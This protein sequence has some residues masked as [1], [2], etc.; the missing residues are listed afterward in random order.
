MANSNSE[1]KFVYAKNWRTS[2]D[3]PDLCVFRSYPSFLSSLIIIIITTI[4]TR[5]EK[6]K[7]GN[8][9]IK[10]ITYPLKPTELNQTIHG[11]TCQPKVQNEKGG[12]ISRVI[13]DSGYNHMNV[14]PII[15]GSNWPKRII[16]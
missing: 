2:S 1:T 4:I 11:C 9:L 7:R 5:D 14:K 6:E 12:Y 13:Q 15:C 8:L 10:R 16:L 3:E